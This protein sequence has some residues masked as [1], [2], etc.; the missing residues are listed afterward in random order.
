[1]GDNFKCTKCGNEDYR[2]IGYRN[3]LP[4]C[5]ACL[6]FQG[7][8][9]KYTKPFPKK[10]SYNLNYALSHEQ[11]K[12]SK[13]ILSH[14]I[15]GDNVLLKAVCGAGKTEIVL[16]TM[17]YTIEKG[18]YVGFATPRKDVV[19]ELFNR[20][21]NIFK[22]NKVVAVYGDNCQEL[23]GDI[24]CLTTHQL[25]RY[26]RYFDLLIIDEIDAFPFHEN[27]TLETFA[28][29]SCKGNFIF[30]SATPSQKVL[31]QFKKRNCQILNLE[32]RYHGY[33]LPIPKIIVRLFAFKLITLFFILKRLINLNHQIFI[34]APTIEKC[35]QLYKW[36]CPFFKHGE[37]V[38]SK[39]LNR[40]K[41]IDDFKNKKYQFLITTSVLERGVTV[42]NLDVIV[43]D[44][45]HDIYNEST[46]TQIAGRVGRKIDAPFGEVIFIVEQINT[47]IKKCVESI[48]KS[49][50]SLQTMLR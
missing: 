50:Q 26:E 4:Y 5:R 13:K 28:H 12:I 11:N 46:L 40:Q 22:K 35:E 19:I 8:K 36:I 31:N 24:I 15:S 33:P 18:G 16:K 25:Y 43:Y 6:G 1:M 44:A 42:K 39:R 27:K 49:N 9:A 23:Y 38:H 48:K 10:A 45:H 21:K 30:M 20:F 29:N 41:I 3:G 7:Q 37:Y 32:K 17:S 14:Y 34:F 47:Q 2:K